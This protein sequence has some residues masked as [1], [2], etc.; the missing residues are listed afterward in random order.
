MFQTAATHAADEWTRGMYLCM[1]TGQAAGIAAAI[2]A[3]TGTAPRDLAIDDL[4]Q[5]LSEQRIDLGEDA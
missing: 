1:V 3:Q 5:A 4:Q 2:S